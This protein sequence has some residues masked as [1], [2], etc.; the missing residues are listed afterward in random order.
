MLI[1]Y[2]EKQKIVMAAQCDTLIFGGARGGGKTYV[3]SGCKAVL[4]VVESY[5]PEE[6]K[7]LNI[8][9]KDF[10]ILRG[11][12][13]KAT[14][15]YKILI[16]YPEY[17]CVIVRETEPQLYANTKV[18]C[19]SVYPAFGGEWI[20]SQGK[21]KFKPSGAEVWLRP[22]NRERHLNFF[23]GPTFHTIIIEELTQ[24]PEEWVDKMV[25]CCRAPHP[26]IRRMKIFTTNPG[27][28]GH[29][30][31]KAKYIDT[32]PAV[33]DGDPVYLPKFNISYQPLKPNEIAYDKFG[34]SHLYIPSLVFDNPWI[35]END[36]GYVR[37]L[38]AKNEIIREMWLFANWDIFA[39][40]F[41][42]MWRV[43]KHIKSEKEFFGV[44]N[45]SEGELVIKRL[46]FDWGEYTLYRSYDYGYGERSAWAC[47]AY[48]VH[49][50]TGD[51]VKFAEIVQ[52]GL[53]DVLQAR[54]TNE[55]FKER[56]N[57]KPEDFLMEI[58]DSKSFWD[59]IP[60]GEEFTSSW[61]K[62]MEAGIILVKSS[63]ARRQGAMSMLRA[64][65]LREDGTP[66]MTY[67][68]NCV[69]ATTS[70]PL[71]PTDKTGLD[72]DTRAWDHPYDENRY[73]LMRV[74]E[75]FG[76]DEDEDKKPN[77]RDMA[78]REREKMQKQASMKNGF[79]AA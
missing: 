68:D 75:G 48:A 71:L 23:Q 40:Q 76:S 45:D 42:D 10:R 11:K 31:V 8:D 66:R 38:L 70:I 19:D 36:P 7:K 50:V 20:A 28:I 58:A 14:H 74:I 46:T 56:Y 79:M 47:G 60:E 5:T 44:E 37:E 17:R 61:D 54:K 63:N 18:E 25:L 69:E 22:C 55:Y 12:D 62:Y 1:E 64:L 29:G 77:W 4:N 59:R 15:Y 32:C 41:F 24:F 26:N 53:T 67:L 6:T 39:G 30:W 9:T 16:D 78:L 21:Y 33:K 43:D 34:N 72:V 3:C 27:G 52:S 13:G 2:S 65:T 35:M 51:I 57:L 73:F 49:N